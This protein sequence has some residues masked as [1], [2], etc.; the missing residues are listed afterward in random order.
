M[1]TVTIAFQRSV[2]LTFTSTAMTTVLAVYLESDG[3]RLQSACL[4]YFTLWHHW[5]CH[6]TAHSPII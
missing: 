1:T 6:N 3:Q 4:Q 2:F 5:H